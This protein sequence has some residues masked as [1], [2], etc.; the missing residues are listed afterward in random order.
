MR[1][2]AAHGAAAVALAAFVGEAGEDLRGR[3]RAVCCRQ[4]HHQALS[5][6]GGALA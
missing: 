3:Q 5:Q 4:D 1:A 6:I 2:L